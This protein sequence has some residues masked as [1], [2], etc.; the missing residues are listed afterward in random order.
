[1]FDRHGNPL[2][3]SGENGSQHSPS[4]DFVL[5]TNIVPVASC[6]ASTQVK[7][8]HVREGDYYKISTSMFAP[9]VYKVKVYFI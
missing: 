4:D 9:C 7:E 1:M 2:K 5:Q 6:N 8:E 3:A